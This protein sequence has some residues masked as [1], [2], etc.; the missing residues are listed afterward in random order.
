MIPALL[1][2]PT[3]GRAGVANRLLL[4]IFVISVALLP[5]SFNIIKYV[6]LA[7]LMGIGV[8]V[9]TSLIR[10]PKLAVTPI[11]ASVAVFVLIYFFWLV[12]SLHQ[13]N[14]LVYVLKD[15]A[16]FP[17]YLVFP[18]LY[19]FVKHNDLAETLGRA[20]L[21]AAF[22]V[23]FMNLSVFSL[24]Y[25]FFEQL[26]LPNLLA[27]NFGLS[28][29]GFTWELG[30]SNGVLRANTKAGQYILMGIALLTLRFMQSKNAIH[31]VLIGLMFF[32]ALLDGH[33]SLIVAIAIFVIIVS[34]MLVLNLERR[35]LKILG[36]LLVGLAGVIVAFV[37]FIDIDMFI[38]RFSDIGSSSFQV[39]Q[40]QI[41][42]LLVEINRHP[43]FGNGFGSSAAVI[44]N[45]LRPFMYEVDFLAVIMKLG[46][47]G[48][49]L[50]FATYVA[51]ITLP[52]LHNPTSYRVVMFAL[53]IGYL[54]YMGT[55]G[56]FAMSPISAFYH[57]LLFL[58]VAICVQPE[59]P[60]G[61]ASPSPINVIDQ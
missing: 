1:I 12:L 54:F 22:L 53:G 25:L 3:L 39:R 60:Q 58:C 33:K 26:T 30:A 47:V 5:V 56:G 57:L 40:G 31:L 7:T 18:V 49:T 15:S 9:I 28:S 46:F 50:Y 38:E 14:N 19:V 32:G 11:Y 23:V 42:S 4:Y 41:D 37:L 44:R 51:T 10:I 55:N 29:L 2:N 34:P 61:R 24:Y 20:I 52:V 21:A 35:P 43:W 48:A 6:I 13:G 17:V 27:A 8:S 16:G 45:E 59:K 36:P